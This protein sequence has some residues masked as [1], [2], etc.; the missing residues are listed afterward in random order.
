MSERDKRSERQEEGE[1]RRRDEGVL[2]TWR[3][4]EEMKGRGEQKKSKAKNQA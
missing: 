3:Q 1:E 2:R 4:G